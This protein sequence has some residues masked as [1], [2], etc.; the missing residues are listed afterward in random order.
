MFRLVNRRLAA[1]RELES[2]RQDFNQCSLPIEFVYRIVVACVDEIM[3]RGLNHPFILKNTYP[4]SVATAMLTLMADPDRRNLFSLKCMRID[5]VAGVMMA[6]LKNLREA[7][8]PMEIQ[9]ELTIAVD[10]FS[11]SSGASTP[12]SSNYS[13]NNKIN[14]VNSLLNH[15]NFPAVNRALLM[16]LLNLSLAILNRSSYNRVKPDMLASILGPRIFASQHAT[17]LQHTPQQA[18][19]Y[20]WGIALANDIKRCSKMFYV[21]LG[22]YRREIL[23]AEEWEYDQALGNGAPFGITVSGEPMSASSL[24]RGNINQWL[25]S[26]H[27]AMGNTG[28]DP[29]SSYFGNHQRPHQ[30]V[31]QL[32]VTDGEDSP[33]HPLSHYGMARRVSTTL[34]ESIRAAAAQEAKHW[35]LDQSASGSKGPAALEH[36]RES[37]NNDSSPGFSRGVN[38][39]WTNRR[40]SQGMST[41]EQRQRE[42]FQRGSNNDSGGTD[43]LRNLYRRRHIRSESTE[44]NDMNDS[45]R[46]REQK[47]LA[48]EQMLRECRGA[49]LSLE[50][51]ESDQCEVPTPDWNRN[52]RGGAMAS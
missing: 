11:L 6:A 35:N 50:S 38:G 4:A 1:N 49:G 51:R 47:R 16:E 26:T 9:E 52:M 12:A 33:H 17:I 48:M 20:G 15:A 22:G 31:P 10:G 41:I 23:G 5:T 45:S 24:S 42:L 30:S 44:S 21:V 37:Q 46:H 25:G 13:F 27:G 14:T 32:R 8:V 34:S 29:E 19:S 43:E 18:Y 7:I 40:Q 2:L 39:S 28:P 3:K 36:L